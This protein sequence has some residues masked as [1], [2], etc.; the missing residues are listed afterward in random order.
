MAALPMS[1]E[2]AM[3][4]ISDQAEATAAPAL[5][6]EDLLTIA[7]RS[8]RAD[9]EGLGVLE[10]GWTPTYDTTWGTARAWERKAGKAAGKFDVE[11]AGVKLKRSDILRHCREMASYWRGLLSGSV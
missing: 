6:N 8:A 4:E 11:D 9:A 10:A 2:E 7:T 1:L 5:S 3:Q